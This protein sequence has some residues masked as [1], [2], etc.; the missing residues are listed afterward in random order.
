[1]K[2]SSTPE[3]SLVIP[4]W[5]ESEVL[6]MLRDRLLQCLKG[7]GVSWEVVFVDDGSRDTTFSQLAA[8]HAEDSRFK[9]I[10]LS[11]NFGHQAAIL[12]GLHH[13]TG[14]AVGVMDA[15]LQDPPEIFGPCLAKLKEGYDVVYAVRKK[16]KEHA[17]KRAAYALFYRFLRFVAEVD[18]PLDSGDFCLMRQRVVATLR[19]MPERNVFVRGLRAW[20]GFR[21]IGLEYE[22]DSRAAG[23]TKYPFKRLLRLATDGVF[24]F[25]TLPLRMATYAGFA[26]VA[27]SVVAGL[28]VLAWRIIGFRFMGHTATEL[29]GWAA[30]AGGMLFIAGV[31]FLILG[32]MGEYLGRIYAEVKQRPRWIIRET[33]GLPLTDDGYQPGEP[34]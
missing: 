11:R 12:A 25:S 2:P 8:L 5:N 23:E 20:T 9:V 7:L 33:L 17:L 21:Q 3:L 30:V 18:I 26:A 13:A 4:C 32:C 14:Q 24:A 34:P 19:R 27:L 29:P 6:P 31:Q 22:R 15:D 10:S 28:F 1:L 16:R